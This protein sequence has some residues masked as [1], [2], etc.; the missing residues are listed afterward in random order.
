MIKKEKTQPVT[1]IDL[2]AG[3]GGFHCAFHALGAECVFASENNPY[4]RQTYEHN[5]K[6]INSYLFTSKRFYGDIFKM[7]Q[8]DMS[9]LP[10][11]DI[12]CAGFPC[13][14]YSHIGSKQ[15]FEDERSYAF[16]VIKDILCIKRPAVFFLE[17]VS[18]ILRH[19]EGKTF[20]AMLNIL[21]DQLGYT[22]YYYIVKAYDFGLPQNR[23]R[24]FIIGFRSEDEYRKT[25]IPPDKIPLTMTMSDIFQGKCNKEI[26]Y[27]LRV[28][29]RGS[30][31]N[32]RHNWDGYIVD[33]KERRLTP[34]E[35]AAMQGFSDDFEFPV[36]D[37]QAM[38]QLGN[39]VAIH[40]VQAY[41]QAILNRMQ[42]I[43]K[44]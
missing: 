37:N 9:H 15:G 25:F 16:F 40:A 29:G 34:K 36:S 18:H 7:T 14:P 26:G 42:T 32:D 43:V 5:F 24:I 6:K 38:K 11:F 30:L 41:G 19:N 4:A 28:S 33:G 27:T 8:E 12:L 21:Q 22:V 35:A 10:Y 17:N 20:D 1:F 31:L 13:Q 39:S 3:I 44:R 23:R 2:F